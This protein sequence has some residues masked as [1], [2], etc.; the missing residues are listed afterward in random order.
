M[1]GGIKHTESYTRQKNRTN[2]HTRP[3]RPSTRDRRARS[4]IKTQQAEEK[5][6]KRRSQGHNQWHDQG[7]QARGRTKGPRSRVRK[8]KG[9]SEIKAAKP[10]AEPEE[11]KPKFKSRGI[12]DWKTKGT[13]QRQEKSRKDQVQGDE[14]EK[15]RQQQEQQRKQ[16]GMFFFLESFSNFQLFSKWVFFFSKFFCGFPRP[17]EM[18]FVVFDFFPSGL[19]FY[20]PGV[21]G[22]FSFL[23]GGYHMLCSS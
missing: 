9:E 8:T 12:E 6:L 10:K 4:R 18:L 23:W 11:P 13:K 14:A 16:R 15:T 17:G 1:R 7:Q 21:F 3:K 22:L 2:E 19:F 20:F 5:N